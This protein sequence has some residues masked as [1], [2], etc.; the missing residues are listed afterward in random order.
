M[1]V[2]IKYK[3]N[4][5][6]SANTEITK[7]IKTSGKYCEADIIVENT[8]DGGITP[9]GNI[10]I[11]DTNVTDVTQYATAQVVDA[12]LVASNIKKDVNI[13]GVVGT[14]EG[15]GGGSLPSSISKIDGGSFTLA[16]DTSQLSYVI[17]HNLG[18]MPKFFIIWT[19]D[20]ND[21]VPS[22]A[23][24][25][26]YMVSYREINLVLSDGT[27]YKGSYTSYYRQ[28]TGGAAE[29][30]GTFYENKNPKQSDYIT[31][32]TFKTNRSDDY[33]K[34]GCTYKWLAWA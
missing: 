13:L 4:T 21:Y 8:P 11:T 3:G 22:Y 18:V 1:S 23:Q 15:G 30:S 6:A 27:V 17:S 34:A 10:N 31:S 9:T 33:Y 2:E 5:I 12:D 24:R 26:T 32:S 7:T 14:F 19:D 25:Y 28:T 29:A 16:S 20:L